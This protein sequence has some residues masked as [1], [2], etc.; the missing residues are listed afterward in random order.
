MIKPAPADY[1]RWL[2]DL[3]SY[4]LDAASSPTGQPDAMGLYTQGVHK[5]IMI[6]QAFYR[7]E[8]APRATGRYATPPTRMPTARLCTTTVP[9]PGTIATS[10]PSAGNACR[11]CVAWGR[12]RPASTMRACWS[13]VASAG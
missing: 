3:S 7:V 5:A 2:P 11:C 9:E 12:S 8:Q 4:R 13:W 6:N 1:R 10:S